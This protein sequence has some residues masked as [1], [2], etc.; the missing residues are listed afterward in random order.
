MYTALLTWFIRRPDDGPVGTETC[1]LQFIK[2]DVPDVNCFIILVI[3]LLAHRDVFNKKKSFRPHYGPGVDF[4]SDRN[5][6]Q[7]Y[8]LGVKAAGA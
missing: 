4:T 6:Y 8:F 1:S 2:Y 7:E 5:E 3:K